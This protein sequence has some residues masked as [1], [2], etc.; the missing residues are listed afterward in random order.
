MPVLLN[1]SYPTVELATAAPSGCIRLVQ[2]HQTGLVH[3]ALFDPTKIVYDPEYLNDQGVSPIFKDHMR[4]MSKALL[5][6]LGGANRVIEIGC[7]QGEFVE[8]LSEQGVRVEGFDPAYRGSTPYIK[9][10]HFVFE[11][12]AAGADFIV[13]RHVLEHLEAPWRFLEKLRSCCDPSTRIYI[14]VPSLDWIIEHASICDIFYE[15]VNYFSL[16]VLWRAFS[17]APTIVQSF[18]GQYLSVVANLSAY[19]EPIGFRGHAPHYLFPTNF[20]QH[21]GELLRTGGIPVYIW[22]AGAKGVTAAH[23]LK[24]LGV[25]VAALVDINPFKQNRY[26][27]GLGIRIIPPEQ[28]FQLS[29]RVDIVV[30]N[31]QYIEEVRDQMRTSGHCVR[32]FDTLCKLAQTAI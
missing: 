1:V 30:M 27:G 29:G 22:G 18:G 16:D 19:R 6:L 11:T 14:E 5:P 28:L 8:L 32:S 4:E 9:R 23:L 26:I 3:N 7:G 17:P 20:Q 2:D 15:H 21:L 31:P 13:L 24:H 10:R 25:E 12:D